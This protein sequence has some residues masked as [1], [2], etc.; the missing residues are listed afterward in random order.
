LPVGEVLVAGEK[1]AA[2]LVQRV[3]HTQSPALSGWP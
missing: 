3:V 2:D 1:G